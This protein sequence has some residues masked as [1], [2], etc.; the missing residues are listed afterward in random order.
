M[1]LKSDLRMTGQTIR[2]FNG[3]SIDNGS[4]C[5]VGGQIQHYV[6]LEI[7]V[8]RKPGLL[9]ANALTVAQCPPH[10]RCERDRQMERS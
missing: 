1:Q 9:C 8:A 5:C 2:A 6:V 10:C 3:Q 4:R 7:L